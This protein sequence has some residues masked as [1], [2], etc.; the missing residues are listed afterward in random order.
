[1]SVRTTDTDDRWHLTIR[2]D[3]I[4]ASRGD[5]PSDVTLVGRAAE[6]YLALWNRG[7]DP[8]IEVTGDREVLET[9]HAGHRIRWS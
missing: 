6:L 7:D 4:A 8:A 1:M 2:P 5:G 3:G 9:W